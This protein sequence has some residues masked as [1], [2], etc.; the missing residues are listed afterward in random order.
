[1][2]IAKFKASTKACKE[3]ALTPRARSQSLE[4]PQAAALQ[5]VEDEGESNELA[6]IDFNE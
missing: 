1:M 3:V 5:S 2:W 4:T 6:G